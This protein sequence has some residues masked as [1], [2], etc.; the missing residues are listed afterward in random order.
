[1]QKRIVYLKED[2]GERFNLKRAWFVKQ[3]R[4][5]DKDGSDLVQPWFD[6]I[7]EAKHFAKKRGWKLIDFP[8]S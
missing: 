8:V 1:M 4:I 5:V 2:R 3:W 7:K 6:T